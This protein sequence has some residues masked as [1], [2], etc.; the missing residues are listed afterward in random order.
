MGWAVRPQGGLES[1][2]L[3]NRLGYKEA[4]RIKL[5]TWGGDR[6]P[7]HLKGS[8]R[9]FLLGSARNGSVSRTP[10]SAA[11]QRHQCAD[12]A[13]LHVVA[14]GL[15]TKLSGL[16]CGRG[17]ASLQDMGS[18]RREHAEAVHRGSVNSAEV[19]PKNR[20][21]DASVVAVLAACLLFLRGV[22]RL[23]HAAF[24]AED[25]QFAWAIRLKLISVVGRVPVEGVCSSRGARSTGTAAREVFC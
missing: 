16:R 4:I 22:P 14:G 6:T 17:A 13:T 7:E 5:A 3:Q 9:C 15:K 19:P 2:P 1:T 24:F 11:R 10:S 18:V 25:G 21:P 8:A 12:S 23:R 20:V